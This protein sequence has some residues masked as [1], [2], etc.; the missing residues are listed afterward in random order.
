M[1]NPPTPKREGGSDADQGERKRREGDARG[2]ARRGHVAVGGGRR[3]GRNARGFGVM[4]ITV[5]VS[6]GR[7]IVIGRGIIGEITDLTKL[8]IIIVM[9]DGW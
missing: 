2:R 5:A 9:T 8:I 7:K 6:R 1:I 3:L 4:G